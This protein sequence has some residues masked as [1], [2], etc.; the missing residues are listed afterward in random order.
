MSIKVED[1]TVFEA[2]GF[3]RPGSD[4]LV[5]K[6]AEGEYYLVGA[7][8]SEWISRLESDYGWRRSAYPETTISQRTASI[9]AEIESESNITV[10]QTLGTQEVQRQEITPAVRGLW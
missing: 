5:G 10:T 2:D 7:A 4:V 6:N 3:V 1:G 9:W 8:E